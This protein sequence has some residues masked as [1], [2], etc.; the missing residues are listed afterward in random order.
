MFLPF[1]LKAVTGANGS[2][3]SSLC[4]AIRLRADIALGRAIPPLAAEGG[5]A[6]TLWT[7]PEQLSR[8][9]QCREVA[10][11]GSAHCD[12]YRPVVLEKVLGETQVA[13][14]GR[15]DGPSWEWPAR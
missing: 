14:S 8:A 2:G 1:R 4:R 9:M 13:G 11:E 15:L 7:G 12:G 5:L 3:K 10:P 6:S